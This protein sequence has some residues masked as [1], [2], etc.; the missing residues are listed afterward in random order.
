MLSFLITVGILKFWE[1]QVEQLQGPWCNPELRLL[2][3]EFLMPPSHVHKCFIWV[4]R[5]PPSPQKH[6]RM[7]ICYAKSINVN[8]CSHCALWW[9]GVLFHTYSCHTPSLSWIGSGFTMTLARTK[10]FLRMNK[11]M[12]DDILMKQLEQFQTGTLMCIV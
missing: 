4:L 6:A 9:I 2:S 1:Y 12:N 10:G 7:W 5:L 3:M 8:V 11:W